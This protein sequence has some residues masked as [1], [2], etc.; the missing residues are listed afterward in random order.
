MSMTWRGGMSELWLLR[1]IITFGLMSAGLLTLEG[2]RLTTSD[3]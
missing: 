2:A 1:W 3:R